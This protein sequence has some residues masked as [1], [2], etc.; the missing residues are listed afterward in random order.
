MVVA[1]PT[2]AMVVGGT[3][4]GAR[5]AEVSREV[6][7]V[8]AGRIADVVVGAVVRAVVTGGM[9][10][11]LVAMVAVDMMMGVVEDSSASTCWQRM[12]SKAERR[13]RRRRSWR[14]LLGD[15]P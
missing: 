2:A 6:V 5:I 7:E 1:G 3:G 8:V 15:W 13:R 12:N 9:V 10:F 14:M 11:V 4:T